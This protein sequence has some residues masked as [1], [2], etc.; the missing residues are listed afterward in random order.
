MTSFRF[1]HRL[2]SFALPCIAGLIVLLP[3]LESCESRSPIR[4]GFVGCMSGR[5]S[6]LGT[7]GRNGVMLAVEEQNERDGIQG[8]PIELI[9]RDDRQ[10]KEF[11][12]KAV[13][14]LMEENV[15]AVIG[16][17]TSAMSVA[18]VPLINREKVLM[19][20]PTSTTNQ[21]NDLDDFFLRVMPPNRAE[22]SHLARH[23]Y[24]Q[25][26]LRR[27]VAVY[28][29]SNRAFSEGIAMHFKTTFEE[30]GGHVTHALPFDSGPDLDFVE[31][32]SGLPLEDADGLLLISAARDTA[33]ICQHLH[34]QGVHLPILSSGWAMTAD[35]LHLGGHAVEGLV[36]SHLLDQTSRLDRFQSFKARYRERFGEDP[37]FAAAHAYEAA[38][39][40]FDGLRAIDDPYDSTALKAAILSQATFYGV[41]GDF[42]INR[43]GEPQRE[44]Y[45][46]V[47]RQ[48]EFKTLERK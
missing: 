24:A 17:M 30:L 12:R 25:L 3:I 1:H 45:L 26:G 16:H 38:L 39:M 15:A 46:V 29:V 44:R 37:D 42:H 10:D 27:V 18:T 5:F 28:D 23:A 33:M 36:F 14:E 48:G 9:T 40:V 35:L 43:F 19:V 2:L 41:Q 47:V 4:I 6:D 31:L 22:T 34:L 13:Q 20:S 21:L 7:S 8:R 32:V 11:A